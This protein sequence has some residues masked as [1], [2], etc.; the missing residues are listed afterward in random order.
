[1]ADKLGEIVGFRGDR[2]FNGAVNIDWFSSD[3]KKALDA[4]KAFVFHG[5]RYHGV[6]QEDVGTSHGHSLIDTATFTRLIVRRCYGLEE[7]PFT[8][9]IAGYGTGKSH[10]GITLAELLSNPVSEAAEMILDSIESADEAIGKEIR[11]LLYDAKQPNIVVAVNGMQSFD[12]SIEL[13][14]QVVRRLKKDGVDSRVLDELRPRFSQAIA[15]LQMSN[16]NVK[17]ELLTQFE[18]TSIEVVIKGLEEQ[19]ENYYNK[20]HDFFAGKGMPIRVL[21]GESVKDVIETV[22]RTYCGAG[23]PYRSLL[24]LFDEFGKYTE[25]ATMNSQRAGGNV[26]QD[27]FEVIQANASLSCFVGFIQFELNAYVQRVAPEYKNEILRYITRYQSANKLYLSINIETLI[28]NLFEKNEEILISNQLDNELSIIKSKKIM[29]NIGRWFP[30]SQN[31]RIWQDDSSFHNIIRKGCWPLSPYSTWMLFYL[32]S[33]GKHLQERS[34]FSLLNELYKKNNNAEVGIISEWS[35]HPVDLWCNELEQEFISSE[36]SGQQGSI[37]HAYSSILSKHGSHLSTKQVHVLRAIVLFSKLK[38]KANS[39]EDALDAISELTS[40]HTNDISQII[41]QLLEEFNVI[42]WDGAFNAYDILGDAVPRAHFISFLRQKRTRLYDDVGIADVFVHHAQ[43]WSDHINDLLCDFA[44]ENEISTQEWKYKAV[45]A[46]QNY[47]DHQIKLAH[48]RWLEASEVDSARGTVIFQYIGPGCEPETAL[49]DSNK[50]LRTFCSEKE[51]KALPIIIVLLIDED[52]SLGEAMAELAI[53]G[54]LNEEEKAKFGN[55]I[56]AHKEKLIKLVQEKIE[57]KIKCRY[58]VT[59]AK[60]ISCDQR[61]SQVGNDLFKRI[62][63]SPVQ[64]PFDGFSTAKGNAADT[65]HELTRELMYGQLDFDRIQS[66]PEKTKNRAIRVLKKSWQIFNVNGTISRRPKNSVIN[67]VTM[68][69]DEMLTSDNRISIVTAMKS[70]FGPPYGANI[71]SAG[72]FLGV[73]IAPRQDKLLIAKGEEHLLVQDWI[74]T[75]G[76]FKGKFINLSFLE[77]IDIIAAGEQSSEWEELLDEWEHCESHSSKLDYYYKS[78]ELKKRVSIPPHLVYR[79]D[80]LKERAVQAST[81]I[82]KN[83]KKQQ[84][85]W[86]KLEGSQRN[87]DCS[88]AAWGSAILRELIDSMK[89]EVG[90][91]R[92]EEINALEIEYANSRQYVIDFFPRWL[93]KQI[94]TSDSPSDVGDFKHK[95]IRVIGEHLKKIGLEAEF[96][97]LEQYTLTAVRN[98]E[99]IAQSNQ[100]IR[101]TENWIL[102]NNKEGGIGRIVTI[103]ALLKDSEQYKKKLKEIY[104]RIDRPELAQIQGQLSNFIHTL[105]AREATIVD[106][107]TK[108]WDT[109]INSQEDINTF[110]VEIDSLV[111][112]FDG[113]PNDLSDLHIMSRVIKQYESA[114]ERLSEDILNWSQFNTLEEQLRNELKSNWGE[115]EI[116]WE[117]DEVMDTF[118]KII[119]SNRRKKSQDWIDRISIEYKNLDKMDARNVNQLHTQISLTPTFLTKEHIEDQEVMLKIIENKLSDLKIEWLLEKFKELSQEEKNKYFDTIKEI[120]HKE[121]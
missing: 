8:L 107:A 21:S 35:L 15:L 64:F 9:A 103:R 98:A 18:E 89:N 25:F 76:I 74:K 83:K 49:E 101:D 24:V 118:I 119:G 62:Y 108:L 106:R 11:S 40:L 120:L 19:N 109:K 65:C 75:E 38:L 63:P 92:D 105:K 34:A 14:K 81:E 16:E 90:L 104:K 72:L 31:H 115:E 1:M 71:A 43:L 100:L 87:S 93:K 111:Q 3:D 57:S 97:E 94:F 95:M 41:V 58:Y 112:E 73:Y 33:A 59:S 66:K 20:V 50:R 29:G 32:T 45:T 91:W 2:L 22:I 121:L 99:F 37:T 96:E 82:D 17:A 30:I 4:G 51:C 26:L 88:L 79:A 27:L 69:W 44:E 116:P 86:S 39:K 52:G 10:L 78:I 84:E 67:Q 55:L 5:P 56:G 46:N 36:E 12:L 7:Q 68:K 70:L 48:D 85:A 47:L 77:G 117:P 6:S 113:E 80:G 53:I 54:E 60:E 102:S 114:Y 42:E 110:R 61:L 23:K 28:A 13:T